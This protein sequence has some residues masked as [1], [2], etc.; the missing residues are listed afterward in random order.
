MTATQ[1]ILITISLILWIGVVLFE[2]IHRKKMY[3]RAGII[4]LVLI[5]VLGYGLHRYL[6]YI[7]D[8][9]HKF[10]LKYSEV[11]VLIG[12]YLATV[13]GIVGNHFFGQIK[14]VHERGKQP[15]LKVFPVLKPL[16][17]SPIIFIAVLSQFNQMG[18][19]IDSATAI[20]TQLGLA[21]QNGFFWKTILDQIGSRQ[22]GSVQPKTTSP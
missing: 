13:L 16:I 6:G 17:I 10:T 1:D 4:Q 7:D 12:L 21:F 20:V 5:G 18:V 8:I 14:G 15:K 22:T 3:L 19:Q 11:L 9:D 2:L